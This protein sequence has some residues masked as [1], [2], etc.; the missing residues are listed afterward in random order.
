MKLNSRGVYASMCVCVLAGRG[1]SSQKK[2][3]HEGGT[4]DIFWKNMLGF[5]P[6]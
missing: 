1:G 5:L 3:F 6:Q 4:M 2:N